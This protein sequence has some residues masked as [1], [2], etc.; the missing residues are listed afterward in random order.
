MRIQRIILLLILV[1]G[2]SSCED[3]LETAPNDQPS[4]E[5]FFASESAAQASRI[6]LYATRSSFFTDQTYTWDATTDQLYAQHD[7]GAARS[8]ALGIITPQT[9]GLNKWALC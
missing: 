7:W 9:G 3:F 1:V 6:G 5:A 2:F 8:I 4:A